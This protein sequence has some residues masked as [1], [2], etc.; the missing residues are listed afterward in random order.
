MSEEKT[1]PSDASAQGSGSAGPVAVLF[2]GPSAEHDVSV[3]SGWAIAD[4][5]AAS[6]FTVE[7]LFIDL[8]ARWWSVRETAVSGRPTRGPSTTRRPPGRTGRGRRQRR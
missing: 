4:S 1:R 8:R 5:L 2:G 6:G 3:V 7:R